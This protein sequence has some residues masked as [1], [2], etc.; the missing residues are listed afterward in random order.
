MK[1]L[2]LTIAVSLVSFV[3]TSQNNDDKLQSCK[4]QLHAVSKLKNAD[5]ALWHKEGDNDTEL[6]G[7]L[8]EF[9]KD[10]EVRNKFINENPRIGL[11]KV[12]IEKTRILLFRE[13]VEENNFDFDSTY[14]ISY[15]ISYSD[16]GIVREFLYVADSNDKCIL[17]INLTYTREIKNIKN[18]NLIRINDTRIKEK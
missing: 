12:G 5:I 18:L 7:L 14:Q 15:D 17:G 9:L 13:Y 10:A 3:V 16:N 6:I 1:K 8:S 11:F 4:N 2:L